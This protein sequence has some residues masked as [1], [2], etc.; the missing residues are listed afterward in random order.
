MLLY[1]R[2]G[3]EAGGLLWFFPKVY[4][5]GEED[6]GGRARGTAVSG[7]RSFGDSLHHVG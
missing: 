5:G 4:L 6:A 7:A 1:Y 3:A 2:D